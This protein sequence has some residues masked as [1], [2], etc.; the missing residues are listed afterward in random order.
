MVFTGHEIPGGNSGVEN[1]HSVALHRA[2]V[3]LCGTGS[4]KAK[5]SD[6]QKKRMGQGSQDPHGS[7]SYF[8]QKCLYRRHIMFNKPVH[9]PILLMFSG[10]DFELTISYVAFLILTLK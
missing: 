10:T 5:E 3:W 8:F 9:T 2:P 1:F 4:G 7:Y 6:Y